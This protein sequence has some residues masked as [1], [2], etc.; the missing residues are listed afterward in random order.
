MSWL[1]RRRERRRR[2]HRQ[3]E[4]L[5]WILVP[6]IVIVGWW[7]GSE[8]YSAMREPASALLRSFDGSDSAR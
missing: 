6:I 5:A 1:E 4:I 2:R 3:E 8:V 7:A